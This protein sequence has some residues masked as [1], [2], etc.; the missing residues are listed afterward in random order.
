MMAPK[1]PDTIGT[2][3][4]APN[5]WINVINDPSTM[6]RRAN[7]SERVLNKPALSLYHLR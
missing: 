5:T 1:D 7:N 3:G 2:H 6:V 4:A